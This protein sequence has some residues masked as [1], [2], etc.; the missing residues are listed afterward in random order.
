[1]LYRILTTRAISEKV[2]SFTTKRVQLGSK[3]YTLSGLQHDYIYQSY[4]SIFGNDV[5]F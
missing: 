3:S 2:S 1:M 5:A 4:V